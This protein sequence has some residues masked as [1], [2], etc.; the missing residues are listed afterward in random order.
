MSL[1]A[2]TS[3][4]TRASMAAMVTVSALFEWFARRGHQ[5][6]DRSRGRHFLQLSVGRLVRPPSSCRPLADDTQGASEALRLQ[7]TPEL[8]AVTAALGPLRL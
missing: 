2:S 1:R 4:G 7:T 3:A 6:R 5:S 8:C